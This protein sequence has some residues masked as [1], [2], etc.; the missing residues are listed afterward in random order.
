MDGSGARTFWGPRMV[1]SDA[2]KPTEHYYQYFNEAMDQMVRVLDG[3]VPVEEGVGDDDGSD[4]FG[5]G[6]F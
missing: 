3:W 5:A 2:P 1:V 6:G 4:L